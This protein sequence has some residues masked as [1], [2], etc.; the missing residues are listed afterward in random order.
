MHMFFIR[1]TYF[2]KSISMHIK[3]DIC[4]YHYRKVKE[5]VCSHLWHGKIFS[6]LHMYI[7]LFVIEQGFSNLVMDTNMDVGGDG[8][9]F[10]IYFIL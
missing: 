6:A 9:L 4:Q 10:P 2:E 1:K 5:C 3:L 7:C 8:C